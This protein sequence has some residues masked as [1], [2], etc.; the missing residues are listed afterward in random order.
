VSNHSS[1]NP[2]DLYAFLIDR[3]LSTSTRFLLNLLPGGLSRKIQK[4][5]N[6]I[7]QETIRGRSCVNLRFLYVNFSR[8]E[9]HHTSP[10][11]PFS[12]SNCWDEEGIVD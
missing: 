10:R 2:K 4:E 12:S 5:G 7:R 3:V 8:E 1:L 6:R 11:I 9:F